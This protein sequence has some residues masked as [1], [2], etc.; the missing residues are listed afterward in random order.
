MSGFSRFIPDA[1]GTA[2]SLVVVNRD[3]PEALRGLLESTF[4]GQSITV[5]EVERD[6]AERD[7]VY[8][9]DGTEVIARSPL[10]EVADAILLVNSDI[11]V[12]GSRDVDDVEL[13]A[14]IRDLTDVPF[15]LRGY[16]E[17]NRE[18][19]LL[20]TISRYIERLSLE[21]D[22]G[23]HRASFQHL[24]RIDDERGTKTVYD[25]LAHS[26]TD[27]HVYGM[28]DWTP[29]PGNHLTMHG[30]W[31]RAFQDLWFVVHVPDDESLRH[32]ALVAIEQEPGIWNGV[33]TF[34]EAR[35][36]AINRHIERTL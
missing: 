4:D 36:K 14:V 15:R 2:L 31:T 20:I 5:D 29:S 10:A 13:P 19:L 35:V 18:K 30:G 28:P 32:A 8:L 1:D 12:T 34:D 16:P 11:Y 33:W 7:M 24:S 21:H 6:D 22:T 25:R 27:T 17:S 26:E 23:T 9:L 3:S